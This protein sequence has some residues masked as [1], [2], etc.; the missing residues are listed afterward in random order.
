MNFNDITQWLGAVALVLSIINMGW[1]LISRSGREA[2]DKIEQHETKLVDHDRRI[3]SVE[4]EMKHLPS[5]GEV[6][7][8]R[9]TVAKLDGQVSHLDQTLGSLTHAVRRIDDYLRD[10]K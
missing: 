1:V 3:Q 4:S 10:T 5:G 9:L 2:S 6:T 8:L 7:S